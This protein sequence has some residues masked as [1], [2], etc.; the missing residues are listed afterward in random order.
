MEFLDSFF[1]VFGRPA[2]WPEMFLRHLQEA[3]AWVSASPLKVILFSVFV[4]FW[5][6]IFAGMMGERFKKT[7]Q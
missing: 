4:T 2:F 6:L 7:D 5:V 3:L 1:D